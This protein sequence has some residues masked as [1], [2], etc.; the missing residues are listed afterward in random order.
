MLAESSGQSRA[1]QFI[2]GYICLYPWIY[3]GRCEKPLM[4]WEYKGID[5]LERFGCESAH[6]MKLARWGSPRQ[7]ALLSLINSSWN[8]CEP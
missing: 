2:G 1:R 8:G 3:L 7:W 4:T 6:F 5:T